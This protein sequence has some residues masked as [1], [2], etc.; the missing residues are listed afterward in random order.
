[1]LESTN[2]FLSPRFVCRVERTISYKPQVC[3]WDHMGLSQNWEPQNQNHT[4]KPHVS[5]CFP[6]KLPQIG[7]SNP[8][9]G[10]QAKSTKAQCWDRWCWCKSSSPA[11]C[12]SQYPG[13]PRNRTGDN[14]HFIWVLKS[15]EILFTIGFPIQQDNMLDYLT[16]CGLP[17]RTHKIP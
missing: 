12:S 11:W 13:K 10:D 2:H 16:I 6:L 9:F 8:P 14:P 1:M 4:S 17:I 7:G 5:I 3:I 15:Y